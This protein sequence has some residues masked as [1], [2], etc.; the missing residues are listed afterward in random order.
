MKTHP[1]SEPL[2]PSDRNFSSGAP[3]DSPAGATNPQSLTLSEDDIAFLCKI[4][5][6]AQTGADAETRQRLRRMI[7]GGL[8]EPM[9]GE[10]RPGE[11]PGARYQLTGKAERFLAARGVGLNEA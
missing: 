5:E 9:C 4:G 2:F 6:M 8:V 7:A 10:G 3:G 1:P 11:G